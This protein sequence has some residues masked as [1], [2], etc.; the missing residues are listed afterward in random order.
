MSSSAGRVDVTPQAAAQV[1]QGGATTV[2]APNQYHLTGGGLTISYFPDGLGPIGPAGSTHLIYQDSHRT[3][4]FHLND[5]RQVEVPDVGTLLSVTINETVDI[6]STSFT[7][8]VPHVRLPDTTGA[9]AHISTDGIT[10]THRIFAGLIGHAQAESYLVTKL[11]G[12]AL[13][14]ILPL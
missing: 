4:A 12:T 7:L 10:T 6:G 5:I 9:S 1:A 3:L 13:H 2:V 14:G 8:I 11:T